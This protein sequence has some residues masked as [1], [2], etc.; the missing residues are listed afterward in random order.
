MSFVLAFILGFAF[1][2]FLSAG[3]GSVAYFWSAEEI[4]MGAILSALAGIFAA[5]VLPRLGAE[6]GSKAFNPKRWLLFVV[7]IIGPFFFAMAKANLDV[8][9]RVIT[10]K[11]KP[12]IVKI[13]PGL[14]SDFAT[15]MLANSITLTPGT[16]TLFVAAD[17][18]VLYIHT[19]DIEHPEQT[20]AEIKKSLEKY[21][22]RMGK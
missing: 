15:A 18:K 17:N 13:K 6:P 7:Y 11:I 20:K 8:A 9:C 4:I 19:L 1:Y 16:W 5:R 21:I 14:K 12:G 22:L 3:S 10:G 2:L